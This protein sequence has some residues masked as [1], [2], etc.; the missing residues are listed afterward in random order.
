M[1]V[2]TTIKN[3]V[4]IREIARFRGNQIGKN[5]TSNEIEFMY[6]FYYYF[7]KKIGEFYEIDKKIYYKYNYFEKHIGEKL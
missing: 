3:N 6:F 2:K 4:F 1:G 5:Y 7:I